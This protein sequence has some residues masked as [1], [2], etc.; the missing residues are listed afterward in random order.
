[1]TSIFVKIGNSNVTLDQGGA[2]IK[3]KSK[4]FIK[5]PQTVCEN[6]EKP[7]FAQSVNF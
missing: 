2:L 1:M 3:I 4:T 7:L 5:R 6:T